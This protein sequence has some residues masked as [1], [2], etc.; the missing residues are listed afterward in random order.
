MHA[1]ISLVLLLLDGGC[2]AVVE[3]SKACIFYPSSKT[4]RGGH[5][6]IQAAEAMLVE[7]CLEKIIQWI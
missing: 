1:A 3:E 7:V 4:E 6:S 5:N 2:V